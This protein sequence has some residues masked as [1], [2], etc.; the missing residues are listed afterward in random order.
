[1]DQSTHQMMIT[2]VAALAAGGGLMTLCRKLRLPAIVLLLAGGILLGPEM[3]GVVHPEGLGNSLQVFVSLA[4]GL[5]LFEGGLTLDLNGYRTTSTVIRRLLSFGVLITW[6][7]VAIAIWLIFGKRPSEALLAASLVIVTGPTVIIPLLRRI[8]IRENLHS[9]LHWEGVLI[10]PIGVFIALLCYEVFLQQAGGWAVANFLVRILAGLGV[11]VVGGLII[12]GVFRFRWIPAEMANVFVLSS[13]GLV[14]GAAESLRSESGLLAV[15]VAGFLL[16]LCKLPELKQVRQFKAEISDLLIGMLFILLTARLQFSQFQNLGLTG[17][18]AIGAIVFWIR[19]L[20]ILACTWKSGL[21]WREKLFLGW[22]APRGIVAASMASLFAM[23]LQQSGADDPRFVETFTYSV[24]IMTVVLQ[25]FTAG[26]LAQL[27]GLK[28]RTPNDWLIVGAHAFG[29]EL[30]RFIGQTG[31]RRAV[32]LDSN[33]RDVAL[34]KAAGLEAIEANVLDPE[35]ETHQNLQGIGHLL[36]VTDNED[37]NELACERWRESLGPDNLCRWAATSQSPRH[38]ARPGI[39]T[40]VFSGLPKPSLISGELERS[41]TTMQI[42]TVSAGESLP[43]GNMLLSITRKGVL[44]PAPTSGNQLK[45]TVVALMMKRKTGYLRCSL[46]PE[47]TVE[48]TAASQA[49]LLEQLV[50]RVVEQEPGIDRNAILNELLE[51]EATFPTALGHE[52]ALPHCH[53]RKLHSRICA[54]ARLPEA[55]GFGKG[56]DCQPVRLV[57]LL[58]SPH[59]DPEGHLATMAEIARLVMDESNRQRLF[60]AVDATGLY[61]EMATLPDPN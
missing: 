60:N 36:A 37:L 15:T 53:C 4:V 14:F 59:G 46:R 28:R 54:V 33:A 45:E 27:L 55:V 7:G 21:D 50:D 9:I 30:A 39:G 31:G 48:L 8:R 17:L 61:L 49:A 43:E 32:L 58:L 1:M 24:I 11:G 41:E 47:L 22:V 34:A 56:V 26:P 29:R 25:G 52:I 44:Q 5:I 42:A 6:F 40:I 23:G 12:H 38:H 10:D 2:V 16:G 3:L 13:A 51:R 20:N 57:F 35:L 18:V 19:P